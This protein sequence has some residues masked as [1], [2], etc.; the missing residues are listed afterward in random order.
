[1]EPGQRPGLAP[2]RGDE[3]EQQQRGQCQRSWLLRPRWERCDE[4]AVRA[5][6]AE[7]PPADFEPIREP[8]RKGRSRFARRTAQIRDRPRRLSDR[9]IAGPAVGRRSAQPE[10]AH[11]PATEAR[12][13]PQACRA[14][15]H[16]KPA[17]REQYGGRSIFDVDS[18]RQKNGAAGTPPAVAGTVPYAQAPKAT[19]CFIDGRQEPHNTNYRPRTWQAVPVVTVIR[20]EDLQRRKQPSP[21]KGDSDSTT[22]AVPGGKFE[23][24]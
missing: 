13:S 18:N 11:V 17:D 10:R 15:M 19:K 21:G 4:Y 8:S 5:R 1:M 6:F 2:P 16:G 14:S 20:I 3:K 23:P 24:G 22:D 7:P 12:T 9:L